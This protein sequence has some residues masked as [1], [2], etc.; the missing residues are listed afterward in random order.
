MS[1]IAESVGVIGAGAMGLGIVRSLL[2]GGFG[3][4][5]RDIRPQAEDDAAR[6][7]ARC[8]PSPAAVARAC[9]ITLVV[10][11][12]RGEIEDVLFGRDGVAPALAP[13]SLVLIA[14]TIAPDDIADFAARI[15]ATPGELVD[16]PISGGPQ[17]A[18][19]GTMTMMVAGSAAALDRCAPVFAAIAGK[20][21]PVGGRPGDAARFKV[22]NNLLAA[23]NLA[24]GAEAMALAAK[25]GLDPRQVFEVI[26]ASSGA[27]WIFADRMPRA[28]AGDY[29]PRAAT[30]VL[31]KDAGLAVDFAARHGV[32]APFASAAQAAFAAAVAAGFGEHD[33]AAMVEWNRRKAGL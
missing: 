23:V 20:V 30:R 12:D 19:D 10:V 17:R 33:D 4:R 28:L 5:V 21:F 16:T 31:R 29:A 26:R 22:I 18:H 11:V 1:S 8:E 3:V 27:S 14:S 7:G 32:A 2:R 13:G 24:A 6:L 25:A 9:S 15:C